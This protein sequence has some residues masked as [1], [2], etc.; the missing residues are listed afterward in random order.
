[1]NIIKAVKKVKDTGGVIVREDFNRYV[2]ITPEGIIHPVEG[3]HLFF[4]DILAEWEVWFFMALQ[5]PAMYENY[6][7][8]ISNGNKSR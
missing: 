3:E 8:E 4:D 6:D 1:M 7:P 2:E 5:T